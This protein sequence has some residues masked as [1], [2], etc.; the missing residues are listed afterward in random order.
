MSQTG[1]GL[2]IMR[3][4]LIIGAVGY[5]LII[6]VI[7]SSQPKRIDVT[8]D[9]IK[10]KLEEYTYQEPITVRIDGR[11]HRLDKEFKGKI[12]L[13]DYVLYGL[14]LKFDENNVAMLSHYSPYSEIYGSK[15]YIN[16]AFDQI[17]ILFD[18]SVI[19]D[20]KIEDN[21]LITAPA[22]NRDEAMVIFSTLDHVTDKD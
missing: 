20:W 3:K 16:N 7:L 5:L 11:Y 22:R 14:L 21:L 8:L 13:N 10:Y 4:K 17:T 18:E 6:T 1:K 9:G 19:G 12:Y 15:I 2:I